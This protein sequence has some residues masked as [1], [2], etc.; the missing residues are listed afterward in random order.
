MA[1]VIFMLNLKNHLQMLMSMHVVGYE[2]G[3]EGSFFESIPKFLLRGNVGLAAHG[4]DIENS[5]EID[6]NAEASLG[7]VPL[8]VSVDTFHFMPTVV[9]P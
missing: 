9:F 2:L 4:I 8:M 5:E 7:R 6:W 1:F 3:L